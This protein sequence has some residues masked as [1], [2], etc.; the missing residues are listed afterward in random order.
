MTSVLTYNQ[1]EFEK[2]SNKSN[3]MLIEESQK[4]VEQYEEKADLSIGTNDKE[5]K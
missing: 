1:V 4:D 5:K 2:V 3:D